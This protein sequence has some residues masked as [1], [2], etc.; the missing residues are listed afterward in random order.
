LQS[1]P[2]REKFK[3]MQMVFV[4]RGLKRAVLALA[5]C[6]PLAAFDVILIKRAPWWRLPYH[7]MGF[8]CAPVF[9]LYLILAWILING[10]KSALY[11]MAFLEGIWFLSNG[12]MAL[13][14]HYPSLGIFALILGGLMLAHLA[15]LRLELSRCY[16][17]PEI[18]WYEGLPKKVPGLFCE[19]RTEAGN[20]SYHV[21][22]LDREGVCVFRDQS[23]EDASRVGRFAK[24]DNQEL[25]LSFRERR[26][27][28]I[29]APVRV[30]H[31]MGKESVIGFQFR[32]MSADSRKVLGDFIEALKGEG[33][34]S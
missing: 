3:G 27:S 19:I 6:V 26:A 12:W 24:P 15:W 30:L 34:V 23:R 20:E 32:D 17:D 8:V 29:G 2:W 22:R 10:R 5:L 13:R 11:V 18:S 4:P 31:R 25:V 21:T 14:L 33:Y 16:V 9:I 28:C 1:G 7:Q